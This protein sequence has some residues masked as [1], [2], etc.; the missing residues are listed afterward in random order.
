MIKL[1][2]YQS[3]YDVFNVRDSYTNGDKT[4][5]I[6]N[7]FKLY[8]NTY[9]SYVFDSENQ[10]YT[11]LVDKFITLKSNYPTKI[12]KDNKLMTNPLCGCQNI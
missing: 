2:T 8:G 6:L 1:Q 3:N 12:I 4:I 7:I 9:I 11:D 10:L 5:H